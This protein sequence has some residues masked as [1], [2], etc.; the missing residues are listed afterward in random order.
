MPS[1][2]IQ[3]PFPE[4]S[5]REQWASGRAWG[6]LH[7]SFTVLTSRDDIE[8]VAERAEWLIEQGGLTP[9]WRGVWEMRYECAVEAVALLDG[10]GPVLWSH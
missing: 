5:Q 6:E 3:P 1:S 10:V 7:S 8:N 2:D 9:F 4:G